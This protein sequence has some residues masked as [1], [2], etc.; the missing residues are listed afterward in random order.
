MAIGLPVGTRFKRPFATTSAGEFA[1]QTPAPLTRLSSVWNLAFTLE[2]GP[3]IG[4]RLVMFAN[5]RHLLVVRE[6]FVDFRQIVIPN[7]LVVFQ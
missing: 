3:D 1:R 5:A 7:G 6:L 4:H 2:F